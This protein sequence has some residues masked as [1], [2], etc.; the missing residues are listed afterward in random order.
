MS[1]VSVNMIWLDA[2]DIKILMFLVYIRDFNY[3]VLF[4]WM[5][6]CL[7]SDLRS[8]YWLISFFFSGLFSVHSTKF[9]FLMRSSKNLCSAFISLS[10]F[11]K[12]N[13]HAVCDMVKF[14]VWLININFTVYKRTSNLLDVKD[15]S[16]TALRCFQ[17]NF[18]F[19][20][21][22]STTFKNVFLRPE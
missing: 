14:Y 8:E 13:C 22:I 3:P 9:L 12:K 11:R 15:R 7:K 5:H 4:W 17:H 18:S 16:N 1:P 10:V 6:I 2:D 21:K 20:K 19:N